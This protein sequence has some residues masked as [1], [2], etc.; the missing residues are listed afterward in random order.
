VRKLKRTLKKQGFE[1][2]RIEAIK[3]NLRNK[4][5]ALDLEVQSLIGNDEA[6][7]EN[8]KACWSYTSR[9]IKLEGK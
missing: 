5:K 1:H 3:H 2:K 9:L 6:Y 7:W 8:R 4:I